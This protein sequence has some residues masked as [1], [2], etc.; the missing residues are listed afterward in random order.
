MSST[1]NAHLDTMPEFTPRNQ[2]E[3][4][5]VA[6]ANLHLDE[7]NCGAT[8]LG[9]TP[10]EVG[11]VCNR[12]LY[13]HIEAKRMKKSPHHD[14]GTMRL[15]MRK[16]LTSSVCMFRWVRNT[17]SPRCPRFVDH[18]DLFDW[19]RLTN[20]MLEYMTSSNSLVHV[21]QGLLSNAGAWLHERVQGRRGASCDYLY[22]LRVTSSSCMKPGMFGDIIRELV[23]ASAPPQDMQPP[24]PAAPQDTMLRVQ[25][26]QPP[27]QPAVVPHDGD[28]NP[29]L[30]SFRLLINSAQ[31]F[32][33]QAT[34]NQEEMTSLLAASS[35]H[36]VQGVDGQLQ[37]PSN[38]P[39]CCCICL[40]NRSN[41]A[42]TPCGHVCICEQCLLYNLSNAHR[43]KCPICQT[44]SSGFQKVYL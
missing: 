23:R 43:D 5:W 40:T 6:L 4:T 9:L 14:S 13:I 2:R 22:R 34:R 41:V 38:T 17:S 36:R 16:V 11:R 44:P 32:I 24:I 30:E 8:T 26:A 35:R 21:T 20:L 29:G 42:F 7:F 39:G 15:A 28:I 25:H 18:D 19:V 3:L 12:L 27:S 33:A 37:G 31:D 1:L 10:E